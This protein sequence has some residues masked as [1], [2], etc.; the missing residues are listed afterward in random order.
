MGATDQLCE[1]SQKVLGNGVP[2]THGTD[3]EQTL[4]DEV[5]SR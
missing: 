1:T 3:R 5:H 2:P 4:C